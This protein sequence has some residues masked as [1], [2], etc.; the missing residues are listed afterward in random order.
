MNDFALKVLAGAAAVYGG[1]VLYVKHLA[2]QPGRVDA[3]GFHLPPETPVPLLAQAADAVGPRMRNASTASQAWEN[4]RW[5][6]A[7]TWPLELVRGKF[8][9]G[10]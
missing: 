3:R 4:E 7:L 10:G 2:D 9:V 6:R 5:K 1:S 8:S